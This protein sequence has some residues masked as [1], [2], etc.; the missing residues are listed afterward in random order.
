VGEGVCGGDFGDVEGHKPVIQ[1]PGF[2]LLV[3]VQLE[4]PGVE[5]ELGT[6]GRFCFE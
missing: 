6:G 3:L 1:L 2:T 5:D 4:L